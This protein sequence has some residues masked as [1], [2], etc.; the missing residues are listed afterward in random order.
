MLNIFEIKQFDYKP[1]EIKYTDDEKIEF[2]KEFYEQFNRLPKQKETYKEFKIGYFI[3]NLKQG[4]NKHLKL[5]VLNIFG[6]KE[7]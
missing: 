6:I 3:N 7:F 1:V 5:I 4:Q 2:C